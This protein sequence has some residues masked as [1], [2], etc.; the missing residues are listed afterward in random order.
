MRPRASRIWPVFAALLTV[1]A[2]AG[3]LAA[4]AIGAPDP[5]I[6]REERALVERSGEIFIGTIDIVTDIREREA[7]RGEPPFATRYTVLIDEVLKGTL[8]PRSIIVVEQVGGNG[9]WTEGDGPLAPGADYLLFT[10]YIP[11]ERVYTITEPVAGN[12]PVPDKDRLDEWRRIVNETWCAYD[13]VLVMGKV[14]FQRRA[15]NEDKRYLDREQVGA[16][17]AEVAVQDTAANGCRSDLADLT[18]TSAP[19]GTKVQVLKGYDPSFRVALRL[20]DRHRY[21]Y[22]AIRNDRAVTGADLLDIAGRV[23][24]IEAERW[25]ECDDTPSAE[26]YC[27][28]DGRATSTDDVIDTIVD[29]VVNAPVLRGEIDLYDGIGKFL[30]MRFILDDGSAVDVAGSLLTGLTAN[31]IELPID[32]LILMLWGG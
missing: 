17:I 14:V 4:P 27:P 1:L 6:P 7:R 22:E 29:L 2:A 28:P 26:G 24:K 32:G 18:A 30:R 20:P 8:E 19:P 9:A 10:S 3:G 23:V 13:D 11:G 21:L 31:G 16:S 12:G 15:W 5:S 25:S